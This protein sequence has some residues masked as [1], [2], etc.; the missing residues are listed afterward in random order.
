MAQDRRKLTAF[1]AVC[2]AVGMLGLAYASVPL[3]RLFCQVTGYGGT[4]QVAEAAPGAVGERT[5]TVRFDAS[6]HRDMPW[7]FQ[8]AQREVV[9]RVGEPTLI[10]YVATNPLSV[11]VSGQAS[12]N[13]TPDKA[14]KYFDKVECFCFTEQRLEPGQ[15]VDMPVSFFIDPAI[16][17]DRKLDGVDTITLSYT[18]FR[19]D[20]PVQLSG[21]AGAGNAN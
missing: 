2:A 8:P 6:V 13:V 15:T 3:Y 20:E 14:G 1:T 16:L 19:L 10:H 18:F 7:D 17:Q 9:V 5:M 21:A 11:P 4:T 12:F